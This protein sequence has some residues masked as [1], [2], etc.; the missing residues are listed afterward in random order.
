[1]SED[2]IKVTWASYPDRHVKIQAVFDSNCE[3][4]NLKRISWKMNQKSYL[5]KFFF[6]DTWKLSYKNDRPSRRSFSEKTSLYINNF[7][8]LKF[9]KD[10]CVFFATSVAFEIWSKY[11]KHGTSTF[12]FGEKFSLWVGKRNEKRN[13]QILTIATASAGEFSLVKKVKFELRNRAKLVNLKTKD[14]LKRMK[15]RIF[16]I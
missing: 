11:F 8:S 12:Y 14:D 7:G 15:I 6:A 16:T 13:L 9:Y 10:L 1:M 4:Q 5:I 3:L 2:G